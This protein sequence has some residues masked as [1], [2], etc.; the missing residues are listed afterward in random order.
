MLQVGGKSGVIGSLVR[1]LD[2][3]GKLRGSHMVSGGD[4][5]GGQ[6][7]PVARFAL[8]PGKYRVEVRFSSG[9]TRARELVVAGAHVRGVLDESTPRAE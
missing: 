6:A 4:G 7:S 3:D 5:R 8:E 1:V 9:D 2:N